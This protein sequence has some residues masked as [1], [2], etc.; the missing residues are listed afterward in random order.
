MGAEAHHLGGQIPGGGKGPPSIQRAP[1]WPRN[2]ARLWTERGRLRAKRGREDRGHEPASASTP[3]GRDGR[4]LR[5]ASPCSRGWR[6]PGRPRCGARLGFE[7]PS[8][9]CKWSPDHLDVAPVRST[10]PRSPA[11]PWPGPPVTSRGVTECFHPGRDAR[12]LLSASLNPQT[13]GP[14][15]TPAESN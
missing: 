1:V 12:L 2:N 4:K 5:L 11:R 9:G 15:P 3:R 8:S 7:L 13:Q 6:G 14:L 10:P